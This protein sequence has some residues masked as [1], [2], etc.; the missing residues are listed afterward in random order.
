MSRAGRC[1]LVAAARRSTGEESGPRRA[2]RGEP[3][4]WAQTSARIGPI[5]PPAALAQRWPP[6]RRSRAGDAPRPVSGQAARPG[7]E[8]AWPAGPARGGGSP[9]PAPRGRGQLR[10]LPGGMLCSPRE[11]RRHRRPSIWAAKSIGIGLIGSGMGSVLLGRATFPRLHGWPQMRPRVEPT[12]RSSRLASTEEVKTTAVTTTAETTVILLPSGSLAR[13]RPRIRPA[14]DTPTL[15]VTSDRAKIR[16]AIS[17]STASRKSIAAYAADPLDRRRR[18]KRLAVSYPGLSRGVG[19]WPDHDS[20]P[21][22]VGA[23]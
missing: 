9:R 4:G 14:T 18:S 7:L 22:R 2:P 17:A 5:D 15:L 13:R 8:P 21:G 3:D 11:R 19:R 12:C 16:S 1:A 10:V 6:A 23:S 20:V